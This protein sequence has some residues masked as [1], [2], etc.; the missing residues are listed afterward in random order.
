MQ[1]PL[2][3]TRPESGHML[4][5]ISLF[6]PFIVRSFCRLDITRRSQCNLISLLYVSDWFVHYPS[7][8][9]CPEIKLQSFLLISSGLFSD[10]EAL[11]KST[12][13]TS[14]A[15][16]QNLQIWRRGSWLLF[17]PRICHLRRDLPFGPPFLY[18]KLKG[19]GNRGR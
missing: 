17:T 11:E 7:R 1:H 4:Y 10:C 6:P 12:S 15:T 18:R 16:Y 13:Q 2:Q 8:H 5:Q 9:Q 14:N 3:R 19:R